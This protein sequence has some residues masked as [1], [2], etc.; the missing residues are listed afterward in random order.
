MGR[1]L[2]CGLRKSPA[3]FV[4]HFIGKW[5]EA[6]TAATRPFRISISIVKNSTHTSGSFRGALCTLV[7]LGEARE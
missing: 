6:E 4:S 2:S 7:L 1:G 3:D 5:R